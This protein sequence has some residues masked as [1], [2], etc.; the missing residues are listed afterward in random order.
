MIWLRLPVVQIHGADGIV[1]TH[2][3]FRVF[4]NKNINPILV[5]KF[6]ISCYS[7]RNA[8]PNQ[9]TRCAILLM[10]NG[11][12]GKLQSSIT[13]CTYVVTSLV[14]LH[15]T[16]KR[17]HECFCAHLPDIPEYALLFGRHSNILCSEWFTIL[18]NVFTNRNKKNCMH[19]CW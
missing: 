11:Q 14:H 19:R 8:D 18:W 17:W 3:W 6:N 7:K 4:F 12:P 13:F 16:S 1:G 5:W 2:Q 9:Q 10:R 15:N